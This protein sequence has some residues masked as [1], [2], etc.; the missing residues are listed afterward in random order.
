MS[1]F[2][3]GDRVRYESGRRATVVSSYDKDGMVICQLDDRTRDRLDSIEF[4]KRGYPHLTIEAEVMGGSLTWVIPVNIK[5]CRVKNTKIAKAFYKNQ[6]V[7]E[8]EEWLELK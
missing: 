2:N 5:H 8:T 3:I 6:I 7:K 4:K 1:K